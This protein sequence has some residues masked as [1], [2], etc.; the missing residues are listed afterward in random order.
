MT[1]K[2]KNLIFRVTSLADLLKFNMQSSS[3]SQKQ[4]LSSDAIG[5]TCDCKPLAGP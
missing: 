3:S 1:I 5:Q 4:V 2:K